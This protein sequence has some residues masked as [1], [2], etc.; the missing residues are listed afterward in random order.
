MDEDQLEQRLASLEAKVNELGQLK[1]QVDDLSLLRAKVNILSQLEAK[2]DRLNQISETVEILVQNVNQITEIEK[3]VSQL[4]DNQLMI[5]DIDT[6]QYLQQLL[7]VGHFKEADR[8]TAK[9]LMNVI[10]KDAES[11]APEDIEN[12]PLAPLKIVDRLWRRYSN[13]NFG[14]SI[15]L[16]AYRDVGGDLNTLI[17]QD[18]NL[19]FQFFKRVGW[20]NE[21]Q[22]IFQKDWDVTPSSPAGFLP[23]SWWIT[24]YGLKIGNFILVRLIQLGF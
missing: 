5:S 17:A 15:Q 22:F 24:P 14:F 3:S 2:V 12:Y 11:I 1:N 10:N 7:V 4:Q 21:N 8:E 23:L 9:I 18:Q 13:D 20:R 19:M 6:F 16:K